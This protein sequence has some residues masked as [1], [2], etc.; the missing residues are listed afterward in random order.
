[1][2]FICNYLSIYLRTF[3]LG[4]LVDDVGVVGSLWRY[5]FAGDS[6]FLAQE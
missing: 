6:E 3:I 2:L 4:N 5:Y 1:M